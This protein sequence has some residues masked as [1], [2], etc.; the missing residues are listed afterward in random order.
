MFGFVQDC[1]ISTANAL[2]ILQPCT[3]PLIH[4]SASVMFGF[5]QDCSISTANALEILQ[6]Y[7]KLCTQFML[8]LQLCLAHKIWMIILHSCVA[9]EIQVTIIDRL[10]TGQPY[11]LIR[12]TGLSFG[13]IYNI[14]LSHQLN[15]QR[16]KKSDL[17]DIR[18]VSYQ[19]R[20][21]WYL[22]ITIFFVFIFSKP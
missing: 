2:E 17:C 15:L 9:H 5:V 12:Y 10:Y 3:K 19:F 20:H 13:K 22:Y 16:K 8:V 4:G 7:T 1:S 18:L 6:S 14:Y 21:L 11:W